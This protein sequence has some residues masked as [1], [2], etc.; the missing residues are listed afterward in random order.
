[1]KEQ[2]KYCYSCMS[3][4]EKN[5]HIC[6]VCSASLDIS[7]ASYSLPIG[8][9]INQKYLVGKIIRDTDLSISYIGLDIQK[10]KK[11]YIEEF[12]PKPFVARS[13]DGITIQ[14][15]T[16]DNIRFK[17]LY[18]DILDRWQRIS[19]IESKNI[20]QTKEVL[21]AN[22]S[23]YCINN[24]NPFVTLS[25]HINAHGSISCSECK[26][27]FMPICNLI[28]NL[29]NRGLTHCGISPD[30]IL[31]NP[32]GQLILVGFSLPE[33][34]TEGSILTPT[35]YSGYSAP[36]QY[37]KNMWQ[38]EWTDIYSLSA[39]MYY[40]LTGIVPVD[41]CSRIKKDTLMEVAAVDETIPDAISEALYKAMQPTKKLRF[42]AMA[43]FTAALL[44][45]TQSNTAVFSPEPVMIKQR[46]ASKSTTSRVSL[47]SSKT[48][49]LSAF[50]AFGLSIVIIPTE[51]SC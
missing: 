39:V 9:S 43:Q 45:E 29:H 46:T 15:L 8:S 18:S 27:M 4:L 36:E 34:R 6:P 17:T 25:A 16:Q 22:Q 30:N 32:R 11:V 50:K 13:A 31:V 48:S 26:A 33:L 47:I 19:R 40:A 23:A 5:G 28:A 1:M 10:N 49:L 51:S 21:L 2:K 20:L 41:S 7:N 3:P 12:F 37:F 38:G 35:L 14:T 24:Y 42:T 44:Q